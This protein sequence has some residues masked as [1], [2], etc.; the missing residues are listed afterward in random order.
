MD[1]CVS[2]ESMGLRARLLGTNEHVVVRMRTHGKALILPAAGLVLDGALLGVGVALVPTAYRPLGQYGVVLAVLALAMWT[3]VIPYLRW[4]S[5]TYLITNHRLITR[6]GILSRTGLDLPLMR[7]NDVAYER[8]L[9]DRIWGC[10]TLYVQTAA[11]GGLVLHDVPDVGW[12]HLTLTEML[13]ASDARTDR[14]AQFGQDTGIGR[15]P[16]NDRDLGNDQDGP[17]DRRSGIRRSF[18]DRRHPA[19]LRD[20]PNGQQPVAPEPAGPYVAGGQRG[21]RRW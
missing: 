12:V 14:G 2:M 3:S 5:R 9:M 20:A 21:G 7:V 8:S 18:A 11:E 13:F 19:D 4:R 1:R 16:T 17:N 15:N 6:E 10:G